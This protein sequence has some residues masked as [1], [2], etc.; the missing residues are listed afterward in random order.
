MTSAETIAQLA[1]TVLDK[2]VQNDFP[3]T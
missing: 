3:R 1:M 2:V